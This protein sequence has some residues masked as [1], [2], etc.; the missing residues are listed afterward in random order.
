MGLG[1]FKTI[2]KLFTAKS[3]EAAQAIEDK[4]LVSFSEQDVRDLE[5]ELAAAKANYASIK[6]TLMGVERDLVAKQSEL[7]TRKE[8]AKQL[9]EQEKLELA[10]KVAGLCLGILEDVKALEQQ[11]TML[12]TSVSQQEH[13]VGELGEA[14]DQ[15][16]RDLQAMKAQEKVTKS[17]EALSSVN[18]S[19]AQGTLAKFKER[20]EK[21][22]HKLDA[23]QAT[24]EADTAGNVDAS[25]E[26]ALGTKDA[27]SKNF[28]DSL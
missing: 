17:T 8:Q 19:G 4:N 13:N 18:T 1:L 16:K 5:Q 22:Q 15:A 25:V 10:Q 11:V 28:L 27:A 24:L 21:Q 2:G 20:R 26:A 3:A 12:K 6:A 9:K 7:G 14:V 23:A